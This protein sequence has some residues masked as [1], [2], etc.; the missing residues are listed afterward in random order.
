MTRGMRSILDD[1]DYL[2]DGSS[3]EALLAA[4]REL[5]ALENRPR[6]R[7]AAIWNEHDLRQRRT[8]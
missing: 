6:R 2:G 3:G 7:V 5:P 1:L 4:L 8:A